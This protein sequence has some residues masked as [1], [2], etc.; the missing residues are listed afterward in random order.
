MTHQD[1]SERGPELKPVA[2][3]PQKSLGQQLYDINLD[4]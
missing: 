4:L 3:E 1:R 2:H